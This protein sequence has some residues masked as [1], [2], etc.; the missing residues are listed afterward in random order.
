[1]LGEHGGCT[2]SSACDEIVANV[3]GFFLEEKGVT[4]ESRPKHGL[5]NF[6]IG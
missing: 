6:N 2:P 5:C 1:M 4:L 3:L